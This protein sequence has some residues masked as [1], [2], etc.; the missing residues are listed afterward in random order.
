[1]SATDCTEQQAIALANETFPGRWT[2]DYAFEV[3]GIP[4]AFIV[5]ATGNPDLAVSTDGLHCNLLQVVE[6]R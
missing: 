4:G 6:R 3:V 5:M 2:F 1:M